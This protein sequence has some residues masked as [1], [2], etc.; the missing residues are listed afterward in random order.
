MR[1]PFAGHVCTQCPTRSG[2][3]SR[4]LGKRFSSKRTSGSTC[5]LL[6]D[7]GRAFGPNWS[8]ESTYSADT[9]I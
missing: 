6:P 5:K 1:F 9:A 2:T 8:A 7:G 4:Q 3:V